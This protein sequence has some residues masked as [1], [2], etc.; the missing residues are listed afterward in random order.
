MTRMMFAAALAL[1]A[2]TSAVAQGK[3][4]FTLTNA[5]G[6]NI[7]EVYVAPTKSDDWEEDVMGRDILADGEAV[8]ITFSP[9]ESVCY[10]D[11]KVVW[12]D[13]SD[14][15]WREFNLCEVSRIT[16]HYNHKTNE[17]TAEYE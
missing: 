8:E 5:T 2:S 14:A 7:Y 10:Y 12:D 13:K 1:F 15:D 9:K 6:Y 3:Q 17:T 11:I 16:L 4:D